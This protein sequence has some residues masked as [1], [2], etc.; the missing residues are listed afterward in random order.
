MNSVP[1]N[2]MLCK[3]NLYFRTNK[4][5]T[6]ITRKTMD[7]I[8]KIVP[9]LCL[10]TFVLAVNNDNKENTLTLT[11]AMFTIAVGSMGALYSAWIVNPQDISPN[12]AGLINN[13]YQQMT[14]VHQLNV[15]QRVNTI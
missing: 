15:S 2:S 7:G 3:Y 14:L 9:V 11:L 13:I 4:V 6:A 5:S 10:L 8:S 1:S 12:F